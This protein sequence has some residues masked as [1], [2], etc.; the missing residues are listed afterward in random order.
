MSNYTDS[1]ALAY[2]TPSVLQQIEVAVVTAAGNIETEDPSTPDHA[3]RIAYA[4]WAQQ[5][6]SVAW[7]AYRWYVATNP[8]IIASYQADP[9]GSTIKDSDIQFVV[10]SNLETVITEWVAAGGAAKAAA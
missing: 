3:N 2:N 9:S 4:N 1:Y 7:V 5:N 8:A 6:S 10:N